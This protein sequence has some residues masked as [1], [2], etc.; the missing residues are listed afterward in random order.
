MA[1]LLEILAGSGWRWSELNNWEAWRTY[2]FKIESTVQ[3]A[4]MR[5]VFFLKVWLCTHVFWLMTSERRGNICM[6][7]IITGVSHINVN[8]VFQIDIQGSFIF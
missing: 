2:K 3:H 4:T 8:P 6:I 1:T 5:S 7:K